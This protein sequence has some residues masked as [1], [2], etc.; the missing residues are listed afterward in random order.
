MVNISTRNV[1]AEQN[2][3]EKGHGVSIGSETSGMCY[4][5]TIRNSVLHGTN[6]AVRLKTSRGR[7]GGI[8]DVLYENLTGSTNAGIQLNTHYGARRPHVPAA[9]A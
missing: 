2:F 1:L 8:E 5:I 3:F 7:G 6:L 9:R 4:N